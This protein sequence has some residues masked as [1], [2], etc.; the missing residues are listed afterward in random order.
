MKCFKSGKQRRAEI[1]DAR[2]VHRVERKG[3]DAASPARP[4][5]GVPVTPALLAPNNSYGVPDFVARGYYQDIAFRCCECGAAGVWTAERQ[6]WWYEV[7]HGYV[8]ST[9]RRCAACRAAERQR[10]D[11]ARRRSLADWLEKLRR[12]AGAQR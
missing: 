1:K 7:A 6:R 9:A 2:R 3:V 4:S 12:L 11:D 5:A 10:K 8:Y